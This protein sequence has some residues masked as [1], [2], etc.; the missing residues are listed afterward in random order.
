MPYF[1]TNDH[2]S[3]YYRDWGQGA[4]VVF[5]N[6]IVLSGAMW[7]YQMLPLCDQG[8][9]C[10]AL[11]RRGH[12]R[13]D[14]PGRGYDMNTLADDIAQL[15]EHLD[16]NEVTLIGQSMGCAEVSRYLGRHG[17]SRL[18]RVALIGTVTPCLLRSEDNPEGAP[19]EIFEAHVAAQL[20]DRPHYNRMV[21]IDDYFGLASRWPEQEFISAEMKQWLVRL[22][23]ETSPRAN[24]ECFR[25]LWLD[26][27]RQDMQAFNVPTLIIHGALD[28][29]A[30]LL[31]AQR[32]AR[33]IK[34]SQLKIYEDAAHALYLTHKDR[35][36]EDLLTFIR[37]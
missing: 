23:L 4:P 34:G 3:L 2:S 1:E 37:S 5:I 32:T 29:N 21:A 18:A 10:I 15:L 24:I 35:L 9:R 11:D 28:H 14:D 8:L 20:A 6:S 25:A 7:E 33:A 12:G 13:S 19:R 31:C 17:T 30:P 16:L 27:F 26:D 36:N 22:V